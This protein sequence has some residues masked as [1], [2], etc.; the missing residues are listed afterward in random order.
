MPAREP[1]GV[2]R[3]GRQIQRATD[4]PMSYVRNCAGSSLP[5]LH[6]PPVGAYSPQGMRRP[7]YLN[8]DLDIE[9]AH[10]LRPLVRALRSE[11][12][13]LHSE[14]FES[15]YVVRL[16]SVRDHRG[17]DAAIET[18]CKVVQRL[19]ASP[20]KLWDSARKKVFDV[21]YEGSPKARLAISFY[22][23]EPERK[24]PSRAR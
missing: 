22:P 19:P 21:G 8:V 4:R 14:K 5:Y 9:S 10:D 2:V 3:G 15:G 18:L 16:E 11:V 1:A 24:L 12:F 7:L 13:V 17:P 6:P 23:R 20:R